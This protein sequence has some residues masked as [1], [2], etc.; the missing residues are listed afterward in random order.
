MMQFPGEGER[1]AKKKNKKLKIRYEKARMEKTKKVFVSC[2]WES[3]S[4]ELIKFS[5]QNSSSCTGGNHVR[6]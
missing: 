1:G 4:E 5:V 2:L 6:R 3:S